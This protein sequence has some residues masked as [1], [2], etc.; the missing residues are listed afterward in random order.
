MRPID[1]DALIDEI[2]HITGQD[3][4]MWFDD[5]RIKREQEVN[6]AAFI[7]RMPTIEN[8]VYGPTLD[9]EFFRKINEFKKR[10]EG[11]SGMAENYYTGIVSGLS[12]ARRILHAPLTVPGKWIEDDFGIHCS[13]CWTHVEERTN[14]CPCC[15]TL[16]EASDVGQ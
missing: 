6:M 11:A 8:M 15:G 3:T 9:A 4:I 7:D 5:R 14:Y 10:A 16:M 12:R 1:A 2:K 13:E